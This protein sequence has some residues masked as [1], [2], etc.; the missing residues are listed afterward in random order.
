MDSYWQRALQNEEN[1]WLCLFWVSNS[2]EINKK[3][4]NYKVLSTTYLINLNII[5][6]VNNCIFSQTCTINI[7]I[8]Y[9]LFLKRCVVE[10]QALMCQRLILIIV[11]THTCV[12]SLIY[13]H[14][15]E[16]RRVFS[17]GCCT[18]AK[19]Q[20]DS[21]SGCT[22]AAYISSL[23]AFLLI[24]RVRAQVTKW[25]VDHEIPISTFFRWLRDSCGAR[26][27]IRGRKQRER[28][29]LTWRKSL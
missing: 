13:R 29:C 17:P 28:F 19:L 12:D 8:L 2:T 23:T 21:V 11:I 4:W 1:K 6:Y 7:H 14:M 26:K 5:P 24:C 16:E 20:C 27:K 18:G 10:S 3:H 25:T 9:L 22:P 15:T